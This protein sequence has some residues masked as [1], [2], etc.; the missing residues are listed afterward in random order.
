MLVRAIAVGPQ[1][2]TQN[3]APLH[4][5]PKSSAIFPCSW[6][7]HF[8]VIE[9]AF[10]VI[11]C[12]WTD[13]RSRKIRSGQAQGMTFHLEIEI[14]LYFSLFLPQRQVRPGLRR[15]PTSRV[16]AVRFPGL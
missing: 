12:Q 13:K 9:I 6:A 2:F 11:F 10:P 16:S 4:A 8:P 1:G 15:Q 7:V 14:S 3:P 5:K